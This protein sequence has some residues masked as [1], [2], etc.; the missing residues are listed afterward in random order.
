MIRGWA[1][2]S[3]FLPEFSFGNAVLGSSCALYFPL[4][5]KCFQKQERY[6]EKFRVYDEAEHF[7]GIY[8][9]QEEKKIYE[10]IKLFLPVD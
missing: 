6:L 3:P 2:L 7:I 9:W 8:Q 4:F 1:I 5:G 10:P